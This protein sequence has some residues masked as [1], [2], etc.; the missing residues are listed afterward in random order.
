MVLVRVLV[1]DEHC[2]GVLRELESAYQDSPVFRLVILE[3]RA[4]VP[5]P[6][7]SRRRW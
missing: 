6:E 5:E 7:V 3:P 2:E 1:R 4:T